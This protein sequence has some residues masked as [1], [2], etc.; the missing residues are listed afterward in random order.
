MD[1]KEEEKHEIAILV[2][3]DLYPIIELTCNNKKQRE[4][5][6]EEFVQKCMEIN[7]TMTKQELKEYVTGVLNRTIQSM[8]DLEEGR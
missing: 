5:E 2:E 4:K 3:W 1:K 8:K 7:T 6:I